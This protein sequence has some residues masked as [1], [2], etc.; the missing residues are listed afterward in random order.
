MP[1]QILDD[2]PA[3]GGFELLDEKKQPA[4]TAGR[5]PMPDDA[6]AFKAGPVEQVRSDIDPRQS[7]GAGAR[8]TLLLGAGPYMAGAMNYAKTG[9]APGSYSKGRDDFRSQT[10]YAQE[11]NPNWFLGGQVL[12]GVATSAVPVTKVVQGG[13]LLPNMARAATAGA[14][15]AGI[16]GFNKDEGDFSDKLKSGAES[17]AI[18]AVTGAG[19]PLL[20]KAVGTTFGKLGQALTGGRPKLPTT[21]AIK[22]VST[23]GYEIAKQAGLVYSPESWDRLV[24]DLTVKAEEAGMFGKLGKVTDNL[25]KNSFDLVK[26]LH[27]MKGITPSLEDVEDLKKIANGIGRYGKAG[28]PDADEGLGR[29]FGHMVKDFIDNSKPEDFVAGN[30]DDGLKGIQ[31][32]RQEYARYQRARMVDKI[33]RAAMNMK[34]GFSI[35]KVRTK[36]AQLANSE[37]FA[38]FSPQEQEAI[39][40]LVQGKT[41][42]TGLIRG[43]PQSGQL[44]VS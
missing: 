35:D 9:G 30:I 19:G 3:P 41:S 40:T 22:D 6:S 23:K 44:T 33:N 25:H 28:G 42:L 21:G 20:G 29:Q 13:A 31:Q 15:E 2:E 37:D 4:Y 27:G 16:Y 7:L 43:S 12:G 24:N 8:D 32:G 10:R 5:A 26:T 14:T 36:F 34:G 39:N 17:A 1:F 38:S 18:G 11:A